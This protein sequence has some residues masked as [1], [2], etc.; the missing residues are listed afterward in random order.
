MKS[1]PVFDR[2]ASGI[3]LILLL[4]AVVTAA[5]CL[6]NQQATREERD[7]GDS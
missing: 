4:F 7:C 5:A 6:K 3:E 1:R 2:T